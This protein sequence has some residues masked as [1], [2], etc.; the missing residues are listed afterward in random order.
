MK[1]YLTVILLFFIAG[2]I[3]SGC[4][5]D[6][7]EELYRLN[8]TTCDTTN[9]T[10]SQSVAPLMT[11]HCNSC[12]GTSGASGGWIT[13]NYTGLKQIADN[14]KLV[15]VINHSSGFSPMPKGS[16]KISDCSISIISKWVQDGSPNN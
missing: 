16:G 10:Y 14:G 12:H 9:V 1:K 5:Y 7:E 13:D 4:Y 15:G 3:I 6:K 8:L 2:L 11:A